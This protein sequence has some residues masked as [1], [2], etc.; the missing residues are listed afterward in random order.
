MDYSSFVKDLNI[1]LKSIDEEFG[2][3]Y[4]DILAVNKAKNNITRWIKQ[5]KY[6]T[7]PK[8]KTSWMNVLRY[9][10]NFVKIHLEPLIIINLDKSH[11][12]ILPIEN[13]YKRVKKF[14][15]KP[16]IKKLIKINFKAY[17]ASVK[18]IC[19]FTYRVDCDTL[20]QTLIDENII[21]IDHYDIK[22]N[23]N[24]RGLSD[25]EENHSEYIEIDKLRHKKKK[26]YTIV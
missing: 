24:K 2:Y 1:I 20:Y 7:F 15:S 10:F 19:S 6:H 26:R 17:S 4:L 25:E 16:K 12:Y 22:M 8:T 5:C 11:E 3:E 18:E 14:N 9:Q 21:T 23:P 13:I